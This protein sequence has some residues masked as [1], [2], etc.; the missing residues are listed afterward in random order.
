M[1]AALNEGAAFFAGVAYLIGKDPI[2]LGAG[3]L[4]V[5][6]LVVRFPTAHRVAL[7]I[8]KQEEMLFLER[9]ALA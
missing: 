3:F 5:G 9:Q 2:A 1:G 4:L 8:A 6:A 7:W